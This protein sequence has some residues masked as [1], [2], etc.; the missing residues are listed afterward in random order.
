MTVGRTFS[1]T[2]E[3]MTPTTEFPPPRR[4]SSRRRR[5]INIASIALVAGLVGGGVA[6]GVDHAAG[7]TASGGGAVAT[8]SRSASSGAGSSS[9]ASG[10]TL[11]PPSGS[12]Y[13]GGYGGYGS[14]AY[15]GGSS[16]AGSSSSGSAT[17][18][19]T[20]GAGAPA[21]VSGIAAKVAPA[22]VDINSTFSYQSEAGAGTGVV[23]TANGEVITNNHVVNGATSISVT[24]VGNGKTYHA[25]VVGYDASHDIAVLQLQGA[26]G[27]TTA[28][29]GDSSKASVG[30][31]VVA[32]GNAGGTG[33]TPTSAG[34]S[35]T[36]LDQSLTAGDDLNG[37]S[38]Q[39]G[40][41]IQ[42]NAD[43]QPGDSGGSLVNSAGQ[44]VGIDTAGSS[45]ST[46]VDFSTQSSDVQ[47]YAVPI[48][49]ALAIAQ[50]IEAGQGTSTIHVGETAFLGVETSAT[51]AQ[52]SGVYGG[53]D[54]YSGGG[55]AS[56]GTSGVTIAGVVSGGAA[57][58]AGLAEGDTVTSF[59]GQA[60]N[61]PTDLT[62]LLVPLHPGDKV[63]VGWT[64]SSGQ[65]HT[66]TVVLGS[67]PP[68]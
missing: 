55:S 65:S 36:A 29:I 23:I 42:V 56:T 40:G 4:Y 68:A 48:N 9:G 5:A 26:A 31:P 13:G 52:G 51:D 11:S 50:Q 38:E 44:V 12:G 35:I 41:M 7:L 43:V 28:S 24:D 54:G 62:K 17:S 58:Q 63:Q 34:G 61:S 30:E 32:V 49:T 59:D 25:T 67:G 20:P 53:G 64:D 37:T 57:A 66:G 60:V 47:A 14:G 16:G 39:L 6:L 10:G 46:S 33:G 18:S 8:P 2:E 45:G 27:L 21:D 19:P 22:L 15:P 1:E 3:P